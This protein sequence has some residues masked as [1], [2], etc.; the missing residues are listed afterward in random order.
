MSEKTKTVYIVESGDD[1][2]LVAASNKSQAVRH[3]T[4][5]TI[6]VR[7]AKPLDVAQMIGAG[8]KLET[9]GQTDEADE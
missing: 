2:H 1:K 3:V 8:I 6:S 5:S 4:T 9:A 7:V